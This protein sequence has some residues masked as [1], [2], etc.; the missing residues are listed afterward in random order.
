MLKKAGLVGLLL[1]QISGV[2][3]CGRASP[4]GVMYVPGGNAQDVVAASVVTPARG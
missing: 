3:S 2:S 4:V 1:A